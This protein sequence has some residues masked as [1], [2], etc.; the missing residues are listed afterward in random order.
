MCWR[1][2]RKQV[3]QW[4]WWRKNLAKQSHIYK[5]V[6]FDHCWRAYSRCKAPH[7]WMR[8]AQSTWAPLGLWQGKPLSRH[9]GP[10]PASGRKI[11][12]IQRIVIGL[13]LIDLRNE[14][15]L[16]K[17][18]QFS[19]RP[20]W[21]YWPGAADI[22]EVRTQRRPKSCND[23]PRTRGYSLTQY[24]YAWMPECLNATWIFLAPDAAQP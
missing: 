6:M 13:L 4:I 9:E 11:F 19:W 8:R 24:E 16:K 14:R 12:Q 1:C 23:A 20:A 21:S 15:H 22:W 17:F 3:K 5:S 10:G 18:K 2:W 7:L